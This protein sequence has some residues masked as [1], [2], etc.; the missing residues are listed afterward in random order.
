MALYAKPFNKPIT[1][2]GTSTAISNDNNGNRQT[3]P[4]NNIK[5]GSN[6]NARRKRDFHHG[7][8]KK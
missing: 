6:R 5:N 4:F 8:N 1:N 3:I 7:F 2:N